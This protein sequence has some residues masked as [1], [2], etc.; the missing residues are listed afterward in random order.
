MGAG[1]ELTEPVHADVGIDLRRGEVCVSQQFADSLEVR[2]AI[3]EVCR[4]CMSEGVRTTFFRIACPSEDGRDDAMD[5]TR[6]HRFAAHR[7]KDGSGIGPRLRSADR[8][9][10]RKGPGGMIAERDNAFLAPFAGHLQRLFIEIHR[11]GSEGDQ[12][13]EA[14]PRAVEE[15]DDRCRTL[16]LHRGTVDPLQC[17]QH[18]LFIEEPGEALVEFR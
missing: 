1:I 12:F 4:G 11:L 8:E 15:L 13:A 10:L 3:Q 7:E 2:A 9:I 6:A 17:P 18:G 5:G 14:H 16:S